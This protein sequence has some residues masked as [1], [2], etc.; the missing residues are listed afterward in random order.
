MVLDLKPLA[1]GEVLRGVE[2][3]RQRAPAA[4]YVVG[5]LPLS[6]AHGRAER[7]RVVM[8]TVVGGDVVEDA[9]LVVDVLVHVKE[10]E[11]GV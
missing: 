7:G 9:V 6:P 10:G 2:E 1:H 11:P 3:N 5:L 8:G 4:H